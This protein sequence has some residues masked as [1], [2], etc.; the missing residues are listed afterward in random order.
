MPRNKH[1]SLVIDN[2]GKKVVYVID[3]PRT[4]SVTY[5]EQDNTFLLSFK[6]YHKQ[7]IVG[8]KH[9]HLTGRSYDVYD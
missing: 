4:L 2:N 7:V 3:N 5:W 9:F 1:L 8:A 6:Q